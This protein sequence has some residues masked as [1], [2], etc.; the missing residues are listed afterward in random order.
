MDEIMDENILKTKV[1]EF[2]TKRH[3]IVPGDHII[4]AV[5]GGADSVCLLL[6]LET[7]KPEFGITL[8]AVHVEHGIRGAESLADAEFVKRLCEQ[9]QIPCR[10]YSVCAKEY[11][12]QEKYSVEEAARYLRYQALRER[13]E[14][15]CKSGRQVQEKYYDRKGQA[16]AQEENGRKQAGRVKIAVAHNREDQAETI[17]FHMI[18]GSSLSGL[19]GIKPEQGGIIRPLLNVSR[20]EIEQYLED[21]KQAYRTD[22]TNLETDYTRNRLRHQ[23]FPLLKE[24][25]VQT[26]EHICRLGEEVAQT[27][28]YLNNQMQEAY[29]NCCYRPKR[30][31][32]RLD[33]EKMNVY[34]KVI[35][36]RMI[37]QALS[38]CAGEA[39]DITADHVRQT[40]ALAGKQTGRKI[41]LPYRMYAQRQ[42]GY[43]LICK[44]QNM[45][46][47]SKCRE[48]KLSGNVESAKEIYQELEIP[49]RAVWTDGRIVTTKI[50]NFDGKTQKIPKNGFTKWYD[51]DTINGSL[52]LRNRKTGDF[53]TIGRTGKTKK[54][55]KF[56]V[57]EKIPQ[58]MRDRI[59]LIA[60]GK[61]ILW[62]IGYRGGQFAEVTPD[63]RRI[64]EICVSGGRDYE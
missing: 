55:K 17:L 57:D 63:T 37:Y 25:N 56:F 54:L 10:I 38:E 45:R 3:L 9:K 2:V 34:P 64:L 36:N 23:V 24:M 26:V 53:L 5:S 19:S 52:Q 60:S 13:A 39:K 46:S 21:Q 30:A 43:L 61:H 27:E 4:A 1:K 32:L 6:I 14:E 20:Q 51:Y 44:R 29:E 41:S 62:V 16:P 35:R 12:E 48:L 28:Q 42:Y 11:A 50:L 59:P 15:Y 7:L 18:R 49:G 22:S 31:E 8:E 58:Q 40:A 47:D 33:I